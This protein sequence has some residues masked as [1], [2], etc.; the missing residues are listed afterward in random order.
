M[1]ECTADPPHQTATKIVS[2]SAGVIWSVV[3][4]CVEKP[5]QVTGVFLG[6]VIVVQHRLRGHCAINRKV[7]G[8]IPDGV[9]GF[10]H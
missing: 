1:N 8:S 2:G 9:I 6:S 10:F 5:V 3:G 4:V 7:A